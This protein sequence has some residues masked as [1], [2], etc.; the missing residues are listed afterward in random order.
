ME[1]QN[2]SGGGK[3]RWGG[4]GWPPHSRPPSRHQHPE[5]LLV[6]DALWLVHRANAL[7]GPGALPGI[8]RS[9]RRCNS[10]SSAQTPRRCHSTDAPLSGCRGASSGEGRRA[11]AL[12][13]DNLPCRGGQSSRRC[14]RKGEA[15]S[16]FGFL[17]RCGEVGHWTTQNGHGKM[18][19]PPV[20][21]GC[22]AWF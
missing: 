13:W 5:T 17:P 2:I 14:R 16:W 10:S 21:F 4:G 20:S 18:F 8:K 7:V 12:G 9:R 6:V 19:S 15:F 22:L 3:E 11:P 1:D